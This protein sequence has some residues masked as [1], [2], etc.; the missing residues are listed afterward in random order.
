MTDVYNGPRTS[1]FRVWHIPQIPGKAFIVDCNTLAEA[2][3][4]EIVL[5]NYDLFQFEHNIKPDYSN[6]SGIVQWDEGEKEYWDMEE[7]EV[8]EILTASADL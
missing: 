6:M 5:A 1:Q 2:R 8:T 4:L 7:D 3:Q